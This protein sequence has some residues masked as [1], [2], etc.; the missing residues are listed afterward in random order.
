MISLR[1]APRDR[2]ENIVPMINVSFLLLVF[3][4]LTAAIAPPPPIEI[5]P[6]EAIGDPMSDGIDVYLTASGSLILQDG[7]PATASILREGITQLHVSASFDATR[8]AGAISDLR[9][10]GV[11]SL[12]LMATARPRS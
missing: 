1:R 8:L 3:F 11:E 6:P 12:V 10:M 4:L 7:T 2:R 5:T 9:S